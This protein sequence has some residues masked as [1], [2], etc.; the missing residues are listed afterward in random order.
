MRRRRGEERSSDTAVAEPSVSSASPR[1]GADSPSAEIGES[2]AI[3]RLTKRSRK[4]FARRQ[5]RRRWLAWKYVIALVAVI[6][7]LCAAIWAVYFSSWLSVKGVTVEGE[8]TMATDAQ[9]VRFADVPVGDPLVTADLGA[10]RTRVLAGLPVVKSVD[11][12]RSW[13]DKILIKVTERT[14]VAVVSIGGRLRALDATGAVFWHYRTAPAGLPL[15]TATSTD[16]EALGEAAKVAAALPA[17][18]ARRVDH[19]QVASVDSIS[20]ILRSG[21][22]VD[23][24]SS[25]D[26]ALKVEV[27]RGLRK[28]T[29]DAA[30]Y[31]V[32]TPG[33]P[34]TRGTS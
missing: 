24:G 32:S 20:L 27:F 19:L 14:P 11:V 23:W 4:S 3:D 10:I 1:P 22:Q 7:L 8:L 2:A 13:P 21:Q 6:V 26:S 31:D 15:V 9:V 18:L 28:H 25:A 17:G 29:P 34:F 5:W 30:L 16:S 33:Q 12:S